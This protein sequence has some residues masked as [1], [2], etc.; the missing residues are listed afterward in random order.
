[1]KLLIFKFRLKC[2]DSKNGN[3]KIHQSMPLEGPDHR[4]SKEGHDLEGH[5]LLF[6]AGAIH[7]FRSAFTKS[8]VATIWRADVIFSVWRHCLC[9]VSSIFLPL[10]ADCY[11]QFDWTRVRVQIKLASSFLHKH[12][13]PLSDL[14]RRK[15]TF[16]SPAC[17]Q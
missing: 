17:S 1:M 4:G 16:I 13:V 8:C 7:Q 3:I 5:S 6:I 15:G 11:A 14:N 12:F 10:T 2:T 9:R